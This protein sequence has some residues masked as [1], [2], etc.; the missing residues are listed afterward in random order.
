MPR[1]SSS[2]A[3]SL[4]PPR[5]SASRYLTFAC[6]RK[7]PGM[8]LDNTFT[9]AFGLEHDL[10]NQYCLYG[11]YGNGV[12]YPTPERWGQSSAGDGTSNNLEV[13]VEKRFRYRA[14]AHRLLPVQ[15]RQRL[16]QLSEDRGRS[17]QVERL[18]P[19]AGRPHPVR[20]GSGTEGRAD[21]HARIALFRQLHRPEPGRAADAQAA[22]GRT[23]QVAVPPGGQFSLG[24]RWA[25]PNNCDHLA[26]S[27]TSVGDQ[28]ARS[29]Y[30]AYAYPLEPTTMPTSPSRTT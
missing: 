20:A 28:I 12:L 14:W 9:Y 2:T 24:L 4:W 13:G 22:D 11:H 15:D 18:H 17:E 29:G 16:H 3:R 30:Y 8:G 10:G 7:V 23:L 1:P 19:N 5:R 26:L 25:T 6:A 27:Y 21:Q